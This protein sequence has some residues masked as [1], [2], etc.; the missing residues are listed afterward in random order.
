MPSSSRHNGDTVH[1]LERGLAGAYQL[2]RGSAQQAHARLVREL[3]QLAHRRAIDDRLAYL[4]I[5]DQEL[6]DRLAAAIAGAAAVLAALPF[7]ETIASGGGERDARFLEQAE[8]GK[9]RLA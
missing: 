8:G 9:E 1:L 6:P 7:A 2:E 5:E 4:V 3:L